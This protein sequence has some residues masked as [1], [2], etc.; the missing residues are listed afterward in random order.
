VSLQR[1]EGG[2]SAVPAFEWLIAA[3]RKQG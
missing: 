2:S 1:L 3:L